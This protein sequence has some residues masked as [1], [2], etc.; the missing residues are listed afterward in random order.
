MLDLLESVV[1]VKKT[2]HSLIIQ[3]NQ[4]NQAKSPIHKWFVLAMMFSGILV[5]AQTPQQVQKITANYNK[6]LLMQFAEESQAQ[7]K[8]EKA[9]AEQYAME[10][11]I[12]IIQTT[13][14]GTYIEVQRL[15]PDGTL[16]YYTTT[17]KDAA[18]STRTDHLHVGGSLGLDLEGQDMVA[19]V[20][21]AGHPRMTHREY[22]GPGGNDRVSLYDVASGNGNRNFHAAHV[23]GTIAAS[24]LHAQAKG[25]APRSQVRSAD[26]N[27]DLSEATSATLEGML[28]SNHSYGYRVN[29]IP[30]WMFGAYVML[31]SQWDNLMYNAPYYLM[32]TSAG[33][34]GYS[35]GYNGEPLHP[36]YDIL[37]NFATSK[38]NLVVAN[39][40]DA[41]VDSNGNLI[42]VYLDG[43]SSM[44]PTD[45]LRIKPD[46]A[47]N[48][49]QVFSTLEYSDSAYNYLTGTSMSSPNVT[50]SLLLL[51]EHYKNSYDMF[52]RAATLKGLALHTAD[53][54]GP[55][56][57]DSK[58]GWGLLNTKRAAEA[59]SNN[60]TQSLVQEMVL[61]EGSTI[62]FEVTSDGVNDL[63]ASISWTDL[64]G[65]P[66][67]GI[68][69]SPDP[70]LVNDL[71]IRVTKGSETHYPWRLT[72]A[73]ANSQNGDNNVDPFERVDVENAQGTYTITI[74]HK[75]SLETGSQSFSLI[76]TGIDATC[77][78]AETPENLT[79][80]QVTDNSAIVSWDPIIG[81]IY[82]LRYR[83]VNTGPW[84]EIENIPSSSYQINNLENDTQ[85]EAEVRGKCSASETSPYSDP[86][87]FDIGCVF[88]IANTVE[89]IT[90][91]VFS[92][93]DNTS[94]ATST[95]ALEDF[96]HI[97]GEVSRRATYEIALE[98]NTAGPR[99]NYF[100]V[101]IDWNQNGEWTDEGEMIEV[102]SITNSTGSDGQQATASIT[103]PDN[104]Y[105]GE[106][107]MRVIKNYNASPTDPC[108][109]YNYGQAEDYTLVVDS[110]VGIEDK[111]SADFSYYPNPTDGM[112]YFASNLDIESI[113]V[114]NL[115]GQQ[116]MN[117]ANVTDKKVDLAPLSKGTYLFKVIFNDGQIETFKVLKK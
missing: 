64:P 23:A 36:G 13:E 73:I 81:N 28:L 68:V 110:R 88:D 60:G 50:G 49:V 24:G 53:D 87:I 107:T 90:R 44:G 85:Y 105:I 78:G 43:S 76:V 89:P 9:L 99:T 100:T 103:V 47:G 56:G 11:N 41:N 22:D 63:I 2:S 95:E 31:S 109:I 116:V 67:Y 18:E 91:V 26:W 83:E 62:T 82:D 79:V 74:T 66:V 102:G 80:S 54:A 7:A 37:N 42:S 20:W 10:R 112:L 1:L 52:M 33:N 38:N 94:S 113:T 86:I 29:N 39:A 108:F 111:N 117:R 57:P 101:W 72:S 61:T 4:M 115:L 19:Y 69:N 48:G 65:A 46:I 8:A 59:I 84:T 71:D 25:M 93:I 15:L 5:F 114:Y 32:V 92:N 70:V 55:V 98:G 45:D 75:G 97:Q 16:L 27:S 34:D 3:K 40:N 6:N 12:P 30:D 21:D 51:Q 35:T 96:T 14:D 106:T 104:A 17:N 58:W 77:E